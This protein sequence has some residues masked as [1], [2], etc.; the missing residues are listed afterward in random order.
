MRENYK[1]GK[2]K[3]NALVEP[4]SRGNSQTEN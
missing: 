4:D 2:L 1:P 3:G